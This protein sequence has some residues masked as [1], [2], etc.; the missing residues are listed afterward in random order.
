M[1]SPTTHRH[2]SRILVVGAFVL[3]ATFAACSSDDDSDDADEPTT[4]TSSTTTTT[5]PAEGPAEWLEVAQDIYDRDFALL[6]DPDPEKVKELYAET[7]NCW[8][9]RHGTVEFLATEGEHVEGEA[10]RVLSV[11]LEQS[12]EVNDFVDLTIKV[13]AKAQRRVDADGDIAQEIPA[14]TEPTC[15]ST[16][17]RPD[18][19]DGAYRVHTQLALTGCPEES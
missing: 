18:G 15:V 4:T 1:Q 10:A 7:C 16:T 8:E 19:T 5:Q 9:D 6:Q 13:Q 11:E 12:D 3:V 17:V 14:Q 2:P